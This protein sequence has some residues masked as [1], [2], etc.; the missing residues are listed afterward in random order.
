MVKEN[1][2]YSTLIHNISNTGA[3][4]KGITSLLAFLPLHEIFVCFYTYER[5]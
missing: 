4:L 5:D 2:F 3:F 1:T